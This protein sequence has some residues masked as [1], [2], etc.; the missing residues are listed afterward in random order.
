MGENDGTEDEVIA[1][2]LYDAPEDC[3]GIK[4]LETI[5]NKFGDRVAEIVAGCT[6]TYEEEK[7][8]VVG[9]QEGLRGINCQRI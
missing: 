4:Q 3:G 7:T 1:T 8:G 5:R 2:L 6:D 9:M